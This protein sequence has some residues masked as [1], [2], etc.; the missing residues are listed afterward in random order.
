[1]HAVILNTSYFNSLGLHLLICDMEILSPTAE[2][3]FR[4]D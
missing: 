2:I 4:E 1:M 3:Y